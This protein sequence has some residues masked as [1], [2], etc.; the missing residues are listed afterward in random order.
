MRQMLIT[1]VAIL[2]AAGSL[3]SAEIIEWNFFM[4]GQN[5]VPPNNSDATGAGQLLYDTDTQTFSMDIMIYGIDLADLAPAGPNGTPI[6][7]HNAP[8][9]QNGGIVIDLGFITP[10]VAD[11]QGIRYQVTDHLFG[12]TFGG[13]SSDPNDNE[14]ALFAA[15]LYVNLH[16]N[17]YPG[18]EL[19]G[20]LA[21]A[22]GALATLG[23]GLLVGVRR[24]R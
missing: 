2:T 1:G 8:A 16:T 11:G 9:G 3:A 17:D 4:S 13:V 22:P 6:H 21:P 18:G 23:L 12:G 10:L 5:E 19:R 14:A 15:E 24:R 20:Q 7:I